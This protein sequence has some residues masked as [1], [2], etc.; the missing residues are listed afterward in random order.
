MA[1]FAAAKR[2]TTCKNSQHADFI[3]TLFS[4]F[5]QAAVT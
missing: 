5:L 4:F 1:E 3:S 2:D